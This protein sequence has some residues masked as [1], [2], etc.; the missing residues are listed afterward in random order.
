VQVCSIEDYCALGS[1]VLAAMATGERKSEDVL[2]A[3]RHRQLTSYYPDFRARE[4]YD[5]LYAQYL[6]LSDLMSGY[7]SPMRKVKIIK[8]EI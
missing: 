8:E 6:R 3:M 5:K 1:A 2:D 7:D 4:I